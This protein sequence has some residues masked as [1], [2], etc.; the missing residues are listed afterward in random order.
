MCTG[1]SLD[2]GRAGMATVDSGARSQF[3][4]VLEMF[5]VGG[6]CPDTNYLFL[7]AL[8]PACCAV[9]LT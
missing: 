2:S 4:D 3:H 6:R 7:G 1:T 5:N 9:A 8:M